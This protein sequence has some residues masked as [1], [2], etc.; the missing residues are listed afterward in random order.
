[1]GDR[2]VPQGPGGQAGQEAAPPQMMI[3]TTVPL[4]PLPAGFNVA[5]LRA[6]DGS[7]Q[8]LLQLQTPA[9]VNVGWLSPEEADRLAHLLR[10]TA[11]RARSGLVLPGDV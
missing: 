10:N 6:N 2:G 4:V 11:T 7:P 1:M 5:P 3:P 9:G 8:V